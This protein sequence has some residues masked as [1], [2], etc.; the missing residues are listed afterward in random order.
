MQTTDHVIN[1]MVILAE[2]MTFGDLNNNRGSNS[3]EDELSTICVNFNSLL[4]DDLTFFKNEIVIKMGNL[5]S[6]SLTSQL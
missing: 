6:V 4:P 5:Y 2:N 3:V 1:S